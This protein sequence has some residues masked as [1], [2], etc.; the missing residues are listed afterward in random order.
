MSLEHNYGE[1]WELIVCFIF[2]TSFDKDVE[3]FESSCITD[4]NVNG[5]AAVEF[6]GFSINQTW[7][8]IWTSNSILTYI[9]KKIEKEPDIYLYTN[10]HSITHNNQKVKTSQISINKWMDKQSEAYT[11]KIIIQS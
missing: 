5:A 9:H 8:S 1:Y 7:N 3:K 4:K 6:G 2:K 10:V 11:H